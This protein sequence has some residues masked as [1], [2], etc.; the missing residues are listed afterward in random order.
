MHW[1]IHALATLRSHPLLSGT[2]ARQGKI[3]QQTYLVD[4]PVTALVHL[5]VKIDPAWKLDGQSVGLK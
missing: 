3:Q 2:A 1:A 5:G 4:L